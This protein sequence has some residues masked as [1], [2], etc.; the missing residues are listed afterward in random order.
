MSAQAA[1]LGHTA[2]RM[3]KKGV[4]DTELKEELAHQIRMTVD[5]IAKHS[6]ALHDHKDRAEY[7]DKEKTFVEEI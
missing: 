6:R 1:R 2:A 7:D 3:A 5:S 4:A